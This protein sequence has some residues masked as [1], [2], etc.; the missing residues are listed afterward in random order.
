MAGFALSDTLNE[1]VIDVEAYLELFNE[2]CPTGAEIVRVLMMANK[3]WKSGDSG[4]WKGCFGIVTIVNQEMAWATFDDY[5]RLRSSLSQ[6]VRPIRS[7]DIGGG[8]MLSGGVAT[9]FR[10]KLEPG[11]SSH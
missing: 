8:Q 10:R 1:G 11:A 7:L 6:M 3:G 5:S 9:I 2:H 4:L